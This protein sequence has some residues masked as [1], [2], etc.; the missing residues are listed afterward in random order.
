MKNTLKITAI[1]ALLAPM[2]AFATEV[3]DVTEEQLESF[4]VA[5]TATGCTID[6]DESA[7]AVE[8]ATKYDEE[9]LKAIVEQLRVYDEIVDASQEGGITLVS[10]E[11][12]S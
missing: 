8:S 5:I 7:A 12:A 1:C 6:D 9:T 4:R 2:S 3:V 10:G 11:C